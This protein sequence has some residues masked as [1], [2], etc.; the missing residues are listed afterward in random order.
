MAILIKNSNILGIN[1]AKI[2]SNSNDLIVKV[3]R[4]SVQRIGGVC[5]VDVD[6]L[7]GF[8]G[9]DTFSFKSIDETGNLV[10]QSYDHLMSLDV[11]S[12]GERR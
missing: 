9:S 3:R 11:F 4:V 5:M 12:E 7:G 10:E 2:E 8:C 6:Y 1:A